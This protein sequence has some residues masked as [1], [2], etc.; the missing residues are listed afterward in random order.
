MKVLVISACTAEKAHKP[1][2]LKPLDQLTW[3]DFCTNNRLERQTR[4]L[5]ISD[6]LLQRCTRALAIRP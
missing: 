1:E 5:R 2:E 6:S 4:E 3:E